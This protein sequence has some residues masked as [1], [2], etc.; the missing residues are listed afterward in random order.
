MRRITITLILLLFFSC[1]PAN[2]LVREKFRILKSQEEVTIILYGDS[3]SCGWGISKTGTSYG[4]FLKPLFEEYLDARI[5]MIN[6]SKQGESFRTAK[7]R[8]QEDIIAYRPDVVF[9]MLGAVD[10]NMLGSSSTSYRANVEEFF[11]ILKE[12]KLFVIVLTTTGYK[13]FFPGL[14]IRFDRLDEFNENTLWAAGHH[15]FPVIDVAGYMSRLRNL[16]PDKYRSMFIDEIH[17]NR[18]GQKYVAEYI[19][20]KI[21]KKV[22]KSRKILFFF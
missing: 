17:L 5:S 21:K 2:E 8:V 10:V 11:N 19:F 12:N 13:H 7:K 4:D 20:K 9:I 6:S 16:K 14:D 22:E 18:E 1:I 15:G 3:I